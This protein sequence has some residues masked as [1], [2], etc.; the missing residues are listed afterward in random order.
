MPTLQ[1]I[2]ELGA[3]SA[4]RVIRESKAIDY[5]WLSD[6]VAIHTGRVPHNLHDFIDSQFAASL[7][8]FNGN[9][10]GGSSGG[11]PGANPQS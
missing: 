11:N 2:S 7:G 6:Q 8:E 4:E 1:E 3:A 9:G 5:A 10:I